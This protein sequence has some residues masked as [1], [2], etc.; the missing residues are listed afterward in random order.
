MTVYGWIFMLA[1]VGSVVGLMVF[2]FWRVFRTPR[3]EEH[4]HAPLDIDTHDADQGR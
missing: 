2:C 3:L 4:M 1:S